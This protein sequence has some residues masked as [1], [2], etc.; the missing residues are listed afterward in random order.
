MWLSVGCIVSN[1]ICGE[2]MKIISQYKQEAIKK[3]QRQ[4]VGHKNFNRM[5]DILFRGSCEREE[6]QAVN[7]TNNTRHQ[8]DTETA[9]RHSMG[10]RVFVCAHQQS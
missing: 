1:V 2:D 4:D 5:L 10:A 3:R 9:E 7:Q 6:Q 8:A